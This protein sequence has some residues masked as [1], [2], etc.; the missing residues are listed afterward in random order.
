[1]KFLII[2]F[3]SFWGLFSKSPDPKVVFKGTVKDVPA[4]DEISIPVEESMIVE[5]YSR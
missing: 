2:F 1:M 5:Y 4:R 3:L